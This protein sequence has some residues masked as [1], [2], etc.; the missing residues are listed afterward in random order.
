[1]LPEGK[2]KWYSFDSGVTVVKILGLALRIVGR[3]SYEAELLI[4]LSV[5]VTSAKRKAGCEGGG[6]VTSIRVKLRQL[7]P[8]E[9]GNR[10][11]C[12]A[13]S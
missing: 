4:T 7:D 3:N 8:D 2:L 11:T 12:L 13:S 10:V 5:A 1:M 9:G 6:Q